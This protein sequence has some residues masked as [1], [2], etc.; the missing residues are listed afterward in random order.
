VVDSQS[1]MVLWASFFPPLRTT[2]LFACHVKE[3]R[4]K[5][6]IQTPG[7]EASASV[8]LGLTQSSMPRLCPSGAYHK[9]NNSGFL[10]QRLLWVFGLVVTL[11]GAQELR[12]CFPWVF[13]PN[14][15]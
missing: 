7:A 14:L 1:H 13:S 6:T 9:C 2:A 11:V 3:E 10:S 15:R 5:R 12:T 8:P 4:Y